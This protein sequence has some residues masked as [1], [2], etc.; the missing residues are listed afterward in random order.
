MYLF[1]RICLIVYNYY[2]LF[3]NLLKAVVENKTFKNTVLKK[4]HSGMPR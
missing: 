2:D 3:E 1:I 4:R